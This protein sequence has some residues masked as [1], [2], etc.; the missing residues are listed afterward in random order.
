MCGQIVFLDEPTAGIDPEARR[1]VWDILHNQRA[2][3]TMILTT[4][5]MEEA[6]LLGD[7]IAIMADGQLQC[8]GSS[9]FLKNIYGLSILNAKQKAHTV[10]HTESLKRIYCW[11]FDLR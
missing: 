6:D 7:R 5:F 3:R 2:G 8:C 1:Q 9:I 10:E 4:H 11:R